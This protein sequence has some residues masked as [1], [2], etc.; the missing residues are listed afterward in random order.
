MAGAAPDPDEA[1]VTRL[2]EAW[3]E[4]YRRHDRARLATVLAEDFTALTASGA[5]VTRPTLMVDPPETARS[6]TFS[7][8]SVCVFGAAAISR[9]RLRLELPNRRIDQWFVRFFAKRDGA[10]RA[11]SVAVTPFSE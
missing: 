10:W 4:A 6:L 11:V 3:N 1:E 5:P 2:D 8:R 7:D 9:G